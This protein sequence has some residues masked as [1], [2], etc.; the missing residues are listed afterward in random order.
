MR[1]WALQ[2]SGDLKMVKSLIKEWIKTKGTF[3]KQVTSV[4]YDLEIVE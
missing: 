3:D 4:R 1:G 2:N